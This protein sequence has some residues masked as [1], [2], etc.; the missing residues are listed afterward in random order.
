MHWAST[1]HSFAS[2]LEII[3]P[4][5][6]SEL[7]RSTLLKCVI[8]GISQRI[9]IL[10]VPAWPASSL[11][12][13][14]GCPNV[15]QPSSAVKVHGPPINALHAPETVFL[16]HPMEEKIK[17][18]VTPAT[19]LFG[20]LMCHNSC[21]FNALLNVKRLIG[22]GIRRRRTD[23]QHFWGFVR[24]AVAGDTRRE[25]WYGIGGRRSTGASKRGRTRLCRLCRRC[26]IAGRRRTRLWCGTNVCRRRRRCGA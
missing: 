19:Q 4:A 2:P 25:L 14:R 15:G 20:G 1:H 13:T 5:L 10:V 17:M 7:E 12:C 9:K 11:F 21:V 26:G 24:L 8:Q 6:H 3:S 22:D 16:S 23:L 18:C